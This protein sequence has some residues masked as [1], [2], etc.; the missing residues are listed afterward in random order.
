MQ[1]PISDTAAITFSAALYRALAAGEP[2]EAAVA[3]GR[4]A[5]YLQDPESLEWA[6]PALYLRTAPGGL[7]EG[8]ISDA[9]PAAGILSRIRDV[10][11]LI[12]E[13]T[14]GFV[15]RRLVFEAIERFTTEKDSGYLMVTG[16]PG[17][18]KSS[19]VAELARRHGW[20]HHFNIRRAGII[21]PEAFLANTCAQ[22]IARHRL[23]YGSLPTE[24]DRD[25]GFLTALLRQVSQRLRTGDP[26]IL[27]IDAL[28]E[29][30]HDGLPPGAN[31]LYLPPVLPRGVFAVLTSRP[32][33]PGARPLFET[34]P[35]SLVLLQGSAVNRADA[36]H[37][38]ESYLGR[39]GICEFLNAQDI[40]EEAFL[41]QLAE[42]SEGNFMYLQFV[43]RAI[44]E[45]RYLHKS[46]EE[47]PAGLRQYYEGHWRLMRGRDSEE[48]WA[49]S[50]VPVLAA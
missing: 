43:L 17:I 22:L 41:E 31:P 46:L 38:V 7:L 40:R 35:E 21:R 48:V 49:R 37:F 29:S 24:A 4:T 26:C 20:V 44:E 19:I 2:V 42:K 36:R 45:G 1:F 15:G 5:V 18:G 6:T 12:E 30:D 27:L 47:I 16:T 14:E 50:K 9:P 3:E 11:G 39:R 25:S 34:E 8:L 10:S 28:D 13:K 23:A 33:D 32:L